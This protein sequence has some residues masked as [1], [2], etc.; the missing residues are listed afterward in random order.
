M[1]IEEEIVVDSKKFYFIMCEIVAKN[2]SL[3]QG[4]YIEFTTALL[5][6]N[7]MMKFLDEANEFLMQTQAD[8][9]L[10]QNGK[11]ENEEEDVQMA[12][13]VNS[14]ILDKITL[15]RL[16]HWRKKQKTNELKLPIYK[17]DSMPVQ[18]LH[19]LHPYL[20]FKFDVDTSTKPI[21]YICSVD[22]NFEQTNFQF[23]GDGVS[24]K[25]SKKKCCFLVLCG[26]YSQ[27]YTPPQH[28][29][30]SYHKQTVDQFSAKVLT[31]IDEAK[32]RLAKILNKN[33]QF[34]HPVQ[35]LHEVCP[36]IYETGK[37]VAENGATSDQ[38]YTFQFWNKLLTDTDTDQCISSMLVAYGFG[39]FIIIIII[40]F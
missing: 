32:K 37:C 17:E 35:L 13:L 4:M 36:S 40:K 1:L 34:K 38:K 25:D 28:V 39:N 16:K 8:Q 12:E 22:I 33:N 3:I 6:L 14:N 9:L 5:K 19:E 24:K 15:K 7:F 21:K 10:N 18:Q 31:P 20:I 27:S 2:E 26:L 11:R 23:V 29:I 30:D